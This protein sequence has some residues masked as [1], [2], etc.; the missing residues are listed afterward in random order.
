MN[1]LI[2]ISIIIFVFLIT[3]VLSDNTLK[4]CVN[5]RNNYRACDD[6]ESGIDLLATGWSEIGYNAGF[7]YT[8]D[9]HAN[10]TRAI[11]L[12]G[13]DTYSFYY[14]TFADAPPSSTANMTNVT[15]VYRMKA[16][17]S[18]T[19]QYQ[20]VQLRNQ[21]GGNFVGGTEWDT[22]D[23]TTSWRYVI[24]GSVESNDGAL[25]QGNWTL[26]SYITQQAEKQE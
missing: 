15:L 5:Y 14:W 8:T 3:I 25:T 26:I 4:D 17:A 10:G 16:N 2:Y 23:S 7:V 24:D 21:I 20:T 11:K 1:K 6:A 22:D 19:C 12:T 13:G 18:D 9:E